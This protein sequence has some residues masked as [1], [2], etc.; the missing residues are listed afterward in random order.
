[1]VILIN[2]L[3]IL[4]VSTKIIKE[5]LYIYLKLNAIFNLIFSLISTV[6][7]ILVHESTEEI[8]YSIY[9]QFFNIIVM[10]LIGNSIKTCSN[11]SYLSFTL[12]RYLNISTSSN[13]VLKFFNT[14]SLKVY[15]LAIIILSGAVNSFIYFEYAT[16]TF[17]TNL[18]QLHSAT[19]ENF[20]NKSFY[21][22]LKLC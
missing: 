10:K 14:L 19:F 2:V 12:A 20:T 9:F 18:V 5:K 7:F 11:L 13:S 8:K 3:V 16:V 21:Q 22:N 1:M 4:I 6:R 15:L 17:R